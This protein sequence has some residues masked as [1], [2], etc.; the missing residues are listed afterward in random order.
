MWTSPSLICPAKT[1]L[2][3]LDQC[4]PCSCSLFYSEIQ[5]CAGQPFILPFICQDLLF[6]GRGGPFFRG[7][8][9]T[10]CT[11]LVK[12]SRVYCIVSYSYW[13]WQ[14][15]TIANS[16]AVKGKMLQKFVWKDRVE[17]N[18]ECDTSLIWIDIRTLTHSVLS[19]NIETSWWKSY[20]EIKSDTCTVQCGLWF[21]SGLI[22]RCSCH[23]PC[24][25]LHVCLPINSDQKSLCARL[26]PA[27]LDQLST[28]QGKTFRGNHLQFF[29][30]YW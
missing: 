4:E 2:S 23:K 3:A 29:P 11:S 16:P 20:A 7:A 6:A 9:C 10:M 26:A 30:F 5:G 8:G 25:T 28:S 13:N 17:D 22:S 24:K 1:I 15:W 19:W 21:S 12:S 18:L 27:H 14:C